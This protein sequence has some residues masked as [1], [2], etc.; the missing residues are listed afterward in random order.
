MAKKRKV[1]FRAFTTVERRAP[2]KW[3]TFPASLYEVLYW[4]TLAERVASGRRSTRP[5]PPLMF[6]FAMHRYVM[7]GSFE[8]RLL[9]AERIWRELHGRDPAVR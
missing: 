6:R 5:W 3:R 7:V 8:H 9:E 4:H 2:R 1:G